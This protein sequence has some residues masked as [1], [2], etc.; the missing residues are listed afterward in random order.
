MTQAFDS[1]GAGIG[2]VVLFFVVGLAL[3]ARVDETE[4]V[5]AAGRGS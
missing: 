5:A 1:Q 4:G 2:T 3:L